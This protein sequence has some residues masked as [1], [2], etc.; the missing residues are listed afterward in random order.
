M[1]HCIAGY[2]RHAVDGYCYLLIWIFG[3]EVASLQVNP[4]ASRPGSWSR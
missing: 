2:A 3:G 1:R 4:G